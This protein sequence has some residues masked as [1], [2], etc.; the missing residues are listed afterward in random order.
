[1]PSRIDCL[2]I[3]VSQ[4]SLTSLL[5]GLYCCFPQFAKA[6]P[7]VVQSTPPSD[8]KPGAAS[9]P[10]MTT[11]W[12]V[13]GQFTALSQSH[14]TFTAPY[15]GQNSLSPNSTNAT[16]TDLTLFIGM[17]LSADGELW[18]KCGN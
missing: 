1:M 12:S 9:T 4:A 14:P 7:A 11:P 15:T 17:R 3:Y 10:D 18:A 6:E 5:L 8:I 16:T 2:K 13:S